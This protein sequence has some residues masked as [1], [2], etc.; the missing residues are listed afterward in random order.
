MHYDV[1]L[2]FQLRDSFAQSLIKAEVTNMR[3][4]GGMRSAKEFPAA[5]E[6]FGETI[7]VELS[8]PRLMFAMRCQK[9]SPRLNYGRITQASYKRT[10]QS[11]SSVSGFSSSSIVL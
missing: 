3:P 2:L 6:H 11:L 8:L 10:V 9:L 4:T 5:R 7:T 1:I